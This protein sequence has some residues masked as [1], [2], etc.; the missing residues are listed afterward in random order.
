[1][2]EILGKGMT[3]KG[4]KR[5]ARE[6]EGGW[7]MAKGIG[8]GGWRPPKVEKEEEQE[9]DGLYDRGGVAQTFACRPVN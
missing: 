2:R 1:M 7:R 8:S 4:A 6:D 3:E 5:V 9:R